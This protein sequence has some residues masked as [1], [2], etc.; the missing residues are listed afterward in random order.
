M[1]EH[2]YKTHCAH[3]FGVV[4]P[5]TTPED[6][7]NV[8]L[9]GNVPREEWDTWCSLIVSDE[10]NRVGFV[11]VVWGLGGG[12]AIGCPPVA[13]FGSEVQRRRWLPGVARGEVRFCLGITEPDGM[14]SFSFSCFV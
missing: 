11:G 1:P 6:A 9:P 10:M 3:G 12:N 7:S 13:R 14:Y 2:V 8:P 5:L 4:H